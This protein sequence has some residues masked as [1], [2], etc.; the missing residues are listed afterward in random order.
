[1]RASVADYLA[2]F[3]RLGDEQAYAERVGYRVVRWT[4][5]DVAA[6]AFRFARELNARGIRK[7]D[8]VMI[9]GPNSGAWVA[10]FLGCANRGVIA[11]PM[12][13]AASPDFALRVFQQ[14]QARLLV[15]SQDHSQPGLPT[16]FLDDL[17]NQVQSHS[18]HSLD[19]EKIAPEDALQIVFT[20][21]TTAD[22]KGVVI[23]HGNVLGNVGPL[24]AQ[25][26]PYLKYERFV[27]PLRF[28]N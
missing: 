10:T 20:S 2:D 19:P 16:L 5:G 3:E 12:D 13:D 7:G 27:H 8:R 9:W 24:E 21:G 23:T 18:S 14:V 25:I 11:V 6:L 17:R 28:L 26:K 15:C 22:P 1:M 4:Y